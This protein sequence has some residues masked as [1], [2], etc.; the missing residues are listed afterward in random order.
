MKSLQLSPV[1][2]I[3]P[4]VGKRTLVAFNV[5][6]DG[7]VYLVVA[8]EPLDYRTESRGASF[9]K[10]LPDHPQTYRIIAL[11]E[12]QTVLDLQI[13]GERFNIHDVQPVLGEILLVCRRCRRRGPND[14]DKNGRIY[15]LDG[16]LAREILLG[17]GIRDVQST[18]EGVIWT[19][20]F[21]EGVF[22]NYGWRRDPVG[23]SGLV[24]R[25]PSGEKV[26]DFRPS[27]GLDRICD[28]YA[29]NV[30]R[31]SDVWCYYYTEFPLVRLHRR[32]V[33]SVW[34]TP[35]SGSGAFAVN[36]EYALFQGGY[37]DR[38]AYKLLSLDSDGVARLV[39][40]VEL[41]DQSGEKLVADRLVGRSD[42][43]YMVCNDFL[44]RIPVQLAVAG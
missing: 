32:K 6:P 34:S 2:S 31:E 4:F 27:A 16:K 5:G 43:L 3:A 12:A 42:S 38:D 41:C 35:V 40:N 28:C 44:Y 29:L 26:Y 11:L 15:T 8:L 10:S 7:L 22:G 33:L 37:N 18:S 24:A 23:A 39:E 1:A 25:D 21:D 9:A 14:F 30:E 36:E 17:D 19:S 13:E 20:Y